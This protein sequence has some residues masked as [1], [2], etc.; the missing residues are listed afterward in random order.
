M[1]SLW[2]N[3]LR[4]FRDKIASADPT[5]GGGSVAAVAATEGLALVVMALEVSAKRSD[6]APGLSPLIEK[7]RPLLAAL[8]SHADADVA[9]FEGYMA[10]LHLPK[11][12]PEEESKRK[13]AVALAGKQALEAPLASAKDCIMALGIA[14]DA[15]EIAHA[16][17][18]SDVGAGAAL[19][20][21]AVIATLYNVD[22]N[23]KGMPNGPERSSYEAMRDELRRAADDLASTI[24]KTTATRLTA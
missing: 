20:H 3:T 22:I 4:E 18:V 14:N 12:T 1:S 23:L 16:G 9:A 24:A 7:A 11:T 10:A 6:A 17:I 5:P 15:V 21:G 2:D 8:S 19:I 13:S